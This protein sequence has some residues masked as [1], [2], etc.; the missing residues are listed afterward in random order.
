MLRTNLV[1]FFLI[2]LCLGANAQQNYDASLIPKE[3][4]PYASSVIRDYQEDVKVEDLDNTL[5]HIKMAITVL[6][7]N[8][9]DDAHIE[10]EYNNR[11]VIKNVKGVILN[12]AGIQISK[13]SEGDFKDVYAD[14]GFSLFQDLRVKYYYPAVTDYPYTIV[15][16]YDVR[17][18][19]T[20]DLPGWE[21]NTGYGTSVENGSFTFSCKPDFAIRY[22]EIN[23]PSSVNITTLAD[24]LKTYSWKVSNLK[25]IKKEPFAPLV[26]NYASQVKIAPENFEYEGI[27][28]SFTNWNNLGNWVYNKI[29]INR[30]EI[31]PSTAQYIHQLTDTI[32]NPKLKAKKI[33]EY[34]QSKTHYV[35]VQIGIGGYQPFLASDVD[36]LDYG[37]CKALVNYT[38]GL[39][40]VAGIN[41]YLCL[42]KAGDKKISLLNNFASMDQANHAILCIPFKNDTTWADCTVQTWPFGYLADFTDDREVLACTPEGG[43]IMHTPKYTARDNIVK[44][45]A[46][47]NINETGDLSGS[48]TA[49]FKGIYYDYRDG[50]IA[51]SQK[52][53]L[54]SIQNVYAG[55]NNMDIEKLNFIQDKS[56]DPSTTENITLKAAEFATIDDKRINFRINPVN[57]IS[58]ENVPKQVHNRKNDVY[59]NDGYTVEDDI[60]YTLPEGYHLDSTPLATDVTKPFGSFNASM[61][62]EG[63]KLTYK[64]K[65]ILINGTYPKDSYPDLVDF[66]QSAADADDYSVALVKN[67]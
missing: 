34:M 67:N 45:K 50:E 60:T 17:L 24:G 23:M 33:Y 61:K 49:L 56:L 30:Q 5:L 15:Y 42:V 20:L 62:I 8:G 31:P 58:D 40:K 3:L 63:N 37:D 53:R 18:K 2:I 14:D 48:M 38:Q 55:I 54:K 41:S 59:I 64:R 44:H 51:E 25:A 46:A 11:T 6:N 16:E 7:K 22:K 66:F 32:Q 13:F 35:S 39:L 65:L 12:A 10:L 52:D 47:F 36:N 21:L 29:L 28:G 57:R 4:M 43:K 9:D 19:Q 26:E 1:A 27:K